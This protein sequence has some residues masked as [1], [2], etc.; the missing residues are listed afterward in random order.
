MVACSKLKKARCISKTS[1]CNWEIGRGCKKAI[2]RGKKSQ[3]FN[4]LSK[5][6]ATK[7]SSSPFFEYNFISSGSY[8]CVIS[9][10]VRDRSNILSTI[11]PY[12]NENK[13]D[14]G[15]VFKNGKKYFEQELKLLKDMR[16]IDP[17]NKFTVKL[18]GANKISRKAFKY[19]GN[20]LT[21]LE[22]VSNAYYQIILQNGGISV[23][24][25]YKISYYNSLV[26]L[27]RLFKGL[28]LMQQ[29]KLIHCDIKPE[30]VLINNEKLSLIDFGL[31]TK[32]NKL[33]TKYNVK[34]LSYKNYPYI[35]PEF[36]IASL[37]LKY[38]KYISA[39][40]ANSEYFIENLYNVLE[41]SGFFDQRYLINDLK[42]RENYM[43]GILNFIKTIKL[44]K[45]YKFRDIFNEEFAF[46]VDVFSMSYII[47]SLNK[48]MKFTN[49]DQKLFI[50]KIHKTC[51]DPNP[52]TRKS[53]LD[54]Y[55]MID[56]EIINQQKIMQ[57][58][59]N[60][61][62]TG[63]VASKLFTTEVDNF[64]INPESSPTLVR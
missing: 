12:Q 43:K 21:C 61:G 40:K 18:K 38:D 59:G 42:L 28:M 62:T 41:R 24:N 46:K 56:N 22:T 53:L 64:N 6:R 4:T 50:N 51:L 19:S 58:G 16:R 57:K 27:R 1:A 17:E 23:N 8:G 47:A 3:K 33:Y 26:L 48:N 36:F 31:S 30:N 10:P 34:L 29:K 63:T 14:V 52:Y 39:K 45:I 11:I 55:T 5:K 15:K 37:F 2:Q 60:V 35:P 25:K 20:T 32:S 7:A 54:I 9:P 49:N 44:K 13:K